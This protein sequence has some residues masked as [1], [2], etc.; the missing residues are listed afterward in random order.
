MAHA[1]LSRRPLLKSALAAT[2]LPRWAWA[3]DNANPDVVVVGAGAAGLAAAKTLLDAGL[4]VKIIEA[5]ERIG[6]RAWTETETFR[7]PYDHG[8]HWLHNA[9]RNPWLEYG[10]S[11]GFSLY[12][13]PGEEFLY[14][15][16]QRLPTSEL[17][18][19]YEALYAFDQRVSRA[20]AA[21]VDAPASDYL[22]PDDPWA[23]TIAA[24]ITHDEAGKE[25][26]ELST[27][28]F[29]GDDDYN[30]WFCREGFGTLV[31]HYGRN[32]PGAY[33]SRGNRSALEWARRARRDNIRNTR[34]QGS[35]NHG[36]DRCIGR[37]KD[38]L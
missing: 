22:D 27:I 2:A 8:C 9:D 12:E 35:H 14:A 20:A 1:K 3:V 6:G 16:G 11:N 32:I 33:W 26:S 28:A 25:L 30:D 4:T 38:P 19:M 21:G 17:Y 37:G 10:R 18:E 36:L 31:A 13:D 34:F 23:M 29:T 7:V 15:N 24:V 5:S